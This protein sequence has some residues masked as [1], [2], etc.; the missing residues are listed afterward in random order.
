MKIFIFVSMFCHSKEKNY[1][2]KLLITNFLIRI[3]GNN[4]IRRRW[5]DF[6]KGHTV[7]LIFTLSF[8]NFILI[9]QRLLI[10]RVPILDEIFPSLWLFAIVF[11]I[12]YIPIAILLGRWHRRTQVRIETHLQL[13]N[14]P[15]MARNFRILLDMIDGKASKE[16]IESYRKKLRSIEKKDFSE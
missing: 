16:E 1:T 4:F 7:Y 10:E 6:R 12:A 15:F 9:F 3:M 8:V 11:V 5:D 14:N 2:P 13:M